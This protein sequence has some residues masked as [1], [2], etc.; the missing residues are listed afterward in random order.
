MEQLNGL[1]L[2]LMSISE[3]KLLAL[4]SLAAIF[5]AFYVVRIIA[6]R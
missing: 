5:L 3:T 6:S 4:V 2:S 1:V